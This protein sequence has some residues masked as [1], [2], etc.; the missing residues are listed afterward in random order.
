MI[1]IFTLQGAQIH[2]LEDQHQTA[3]ITINTKI[4]KYMADV[5]IQDTLVK[6]VG[7]AEVKRVKCKKQGHFE[8]MCQTKTS[9]QHKPRFAHLNSIKN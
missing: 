8:N 4:Q 9:N 3:P 6:N 1:H 5:D 7:T 2:I